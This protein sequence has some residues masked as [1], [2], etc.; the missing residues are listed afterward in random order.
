MKSSPIS[1]K[2]RIDLSSFYNFTLLGSKFEASINEY[3][4]FSLLKGPWVWQIV[5]FENLATQDT[6]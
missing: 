3:A 4:D 5:N 2:I 6:L 1:G